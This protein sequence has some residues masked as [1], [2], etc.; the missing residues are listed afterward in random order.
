MANTSEVKYPEIEV[1]LVGED[2]NAFYIIGRVQNA[3]RRG[4]VPAEEVSEF[5][6]EAMSGDFD[7]LLATC[8][9]WVDVS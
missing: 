2:G 7:H 5:A 4:G 9:K 1:Q 8:M 3:L 6:N